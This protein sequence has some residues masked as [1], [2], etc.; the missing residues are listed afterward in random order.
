[1]SLQ[2]GQYKNHDLLTQGHVPIP[3]Y[4]STDGFLNAILESVNGMGAALGATVPTRQNATP[5][6][7]A[8]GIVFY[9]TDTG[10]NDFQNDAAYTPVGLTLPY[11]EEKEAPS[12]Q[13]ATPWTD[14]TGAVFYWTAT[15]ANDFATDAAYTVGANPI[16]YDK[17][18]EQPVSKAD[19]AEVTADTTIAIPA[20]TTSILFQNFTDQ[21]AVLTWG[22]NSLQV[23]ADTDQE[24]RGYFDAAET[25]NLVF[26]AA[27]TAGD[28]FYAKWTFS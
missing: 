12:R 17:E 11:D 23:V 22:A 6:V 9:W 7:D 21:D 13:N 24:F 25:L 2:I 14:D 19:Y 8:N 5:W 18:I 10:A 28:V 1:M 27:P 16:P 26:D 4:P 15:G 20:K 3:T